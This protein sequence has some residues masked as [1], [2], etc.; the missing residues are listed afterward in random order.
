MPEQKDTS[1][2][3]SNILRVGAWSAIGVVLVGVLEIVITFLPGGNSLQVTVQDWFSL[4][5]RNPFLGLRNLGLMNIFLNLL[6]VPFYLAGWIAL[7]GKKSE[8]TALLSFLMTMLAVSVFLSTNRAFPM[9]ALSKQYASASSPADLAALEAA[10]KSLM[11]V[12]ESHTPGTFPAFFLAESAGILLS[13]TMLRETV[14]PRA[15]GW[16]GLFGF[17]ALLLFEVLSSFFNVDINLGMGLAVI[18]GLFSMAWNL[19]SARTLLILS[20]S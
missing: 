16:A 15:A 1:R 6:T 18:G 20:Q 4:Y 17:S 8:V 11:A 10:A 19:L 13:L 9:L 3:R 12:G 14:F 5:Q 2:T 7:H